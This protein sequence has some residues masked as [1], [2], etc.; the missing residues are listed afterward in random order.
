MKRVTLVISSN[1]IGP[2]SLCNFA[3]YFRLD[4]SSFVHLN[5]SYGSYSL[6]FLVVI[7]SLI[8]LF[9]GGNFLSI[10]PG[11]SDRLV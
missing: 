9:P 8:C 5:Q 10:A 7:T 6:L 1:F 11:E 3:Q 4:T 2:S